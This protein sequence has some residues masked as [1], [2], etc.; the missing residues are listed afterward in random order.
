MQ[1]GNVGL[2]I[3]KKDGSLAT[4]DDIKNIDQVLDLWTGIITSSFTVE[5][6]PVKVN[7]ACEQNWDAVGFSIES[8]LLSEKKISIRI[9]F[10]I[11]QTGSL[12]M[13]EITGMILWDIQ[14]LVP[15]D[16]ELCT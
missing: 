12:K 7:T 8:K 4:V 3:K 9:R 11:S 15:I 13:L 10:S 1:L 16:R 5:D 6:I 14:I 2:E